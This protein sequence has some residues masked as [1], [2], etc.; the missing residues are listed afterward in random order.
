MNPISIREFRYPED[1]ARALELW[2]TAGEGVRVGPSDAPAEIRKKLERDPDLFLVAEAGAELVGT[3]I[4]GYDGRRGHVYHLAVAE[5]FRRQGIGSKLM[6]ELEARLRQKGCIRCYLI[7]R[8]GNDGAMR[9]Y[10]A[11]GW[12]HLDDD[13]L[14]AKDL[15]E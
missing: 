15:A 3:V 4:G 2:N 7:V 11:I 13:Y 9:H 1:Y 8:V 14:Y 12:R 5:S 10:E 6:R